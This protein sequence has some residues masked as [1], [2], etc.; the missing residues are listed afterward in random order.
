MTGEAPDAPTTPAAQPEAAPDASG[1]RDPQDGKA[2]P[3]WKRP[4]AWVA[5]AVLAG[6]AGVI[7]G[8]VQSGAGWVAGHFQDHSNVSV[9][10]DPDPGVRDV[11]GRKRMGI[12]RADRV[13]FSA[14][15]RP[16]RTGEMGREVQGRASES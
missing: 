9:I 14:T 4:I 5:A 6:V 11:Y 10:P 15:S 7:T 3:W 12:C 8:A 2:R 13:D 1:G 16:T